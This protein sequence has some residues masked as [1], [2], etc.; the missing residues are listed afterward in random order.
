[1]DNI[2][3]TNAQTALLSEIFAVLAEQQD[4][5]E[6]RSLLGNVLLKLLHADQYASYLW[7]GAVD[8]FAHRVAINMSD[9]NLSSYEAYYQFH[10]PITHRLRERT[11]PTLVTDIIQQRE[12][13][14]TEFFN[15]FLSRDGLYWGVNLHVSAGGDRTG[16]LRIWRS[17]RG[18]NFDAQDLAVLRMIAP[19]FRAAL[20]RCSTTSPKLPPATIRSEENLPCAALLSFPHTAALPFVPRAS[21][22][23]SPRGHAAPAHSMQYPR[24]TDREEQVARLVASGL[25]DKEIA[26]SLGISFA[27]VRAHLKQTFRKFQVD[28]RVKL[29]ARLASPLN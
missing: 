25:S 22:P 19:A 2:C 4:E 20:G 26:R 23:S 12:L 8:G 10:D 15:D 16:D 17:R 21:T 6:V 13:L 7:C 24:L 29:A 27:T 14:R 9:V 1:M 11:A 5:K 28:N 3:L 18:G